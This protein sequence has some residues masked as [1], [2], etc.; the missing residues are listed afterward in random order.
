MLAYFH[1]KGYR[2]FLTM[3]NFHGNFPRRSKSHHSLLFFVSLIIQLPL[4]MIAIA[5]QI[6]NC[7]FYWYFRFSWANSRYYTQCCFLTVLIRLANSMLA[8]IHIWIA[9]EL[10]ICN[11]FFKLRI[12]FR[13][14]RN[15]IQFKLISFEK[16]D[17]SNFN[18]EFNGLF[19]FVAT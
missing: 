5:N 10:V 16:G 1:N 9:I 17:Q 13:T 8:L 6:L 7:P 2:L 18:M 14:R 3:P 4:N 15:A 19:R 12:P 11:L